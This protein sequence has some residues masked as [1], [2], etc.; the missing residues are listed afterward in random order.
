MRKIFLA[1]TALVALTSVSAMASDITISGS[2]SLIMSD[3]ASN[4]NGG[5]SVA[6]EMDMGV[7]FA[8][9]MEN[10]MSAGMSFAL[11]EASGV[12]DGL[13]WT[14]GGDFGTLKVTPNGTSSNYVAA[15]DDTGNYAGEGADIS[16]DILGTA[17][18]TAPGTAVG[19]ALPAI[20]GVS[21]AMEMGQNHFGYGATMGVGPASVNIAQM[22]SPTIDGTSASVALSMGDISVGYEQNKNETSSG[23]SV[24]TEGTIM[25]VK[26]TMGATTLAYEAMSHKTDATKDKESTQI[27]ASYTVTPGVTAVVSSSDTSVTASGATTD[28]ERTEVQLKIS[29]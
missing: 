26:Y 16:A 6:A 13:S 28:A 7:A 24:E 4:T 19:L 15:M 23:T 20:S 2:S 17:R 21:V 25:G 5:G 10:G 9:T 14:L 22:K 18:G 1:S 8:T 12:Y 11:H 3:D 29:F 27:Q